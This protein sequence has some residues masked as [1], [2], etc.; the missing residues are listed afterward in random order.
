M[1]FL[2]AP[3][4]AIRWL[5]PASS[6]LEPEQN[7]LIGAGTGRSIVVEGTAEAYQSPV[8]AAE[9]RIVIIPDI[10]GKCKVWGRTAIIG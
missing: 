9:K 8:S 2:L 7:G 3:N 1:E 10:V 4:K 6:E 5:T